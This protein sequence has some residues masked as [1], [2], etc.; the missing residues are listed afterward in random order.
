[1]SDHLAVYSFLIATLK[2]IVKES[3]KRAISDPPDNLILSNLN[4]YS[5]AYLISL[6]TYLE[7]FLQDLA[8]AYVDQVSERIAAAKIPGNMV[9]WSIQ[10]DTKEKEYEFEFFRLPLTREDLEGEI[11]GNPGRT[12]SIFKK[13]GIDLASDPDFQNT[14]SVVGAVVEKRNRIIHKNDEAADLS[15]DDIITF[16]DQFLLYMNAVNAVVINN[17]LRAIQQQDSEDGS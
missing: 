3:K 17:H 9:R 13:I 11:S 5:K 8:A 14:K 16:A 7:A 15:L 6:C 10:R 4:F 12:I 2:E 1:M